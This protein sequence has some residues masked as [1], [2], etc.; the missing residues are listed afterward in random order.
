MSLPSG[1]IPVVLYVAVIASAVLT[2]TFAFQWDLIDWL[3]PFL[4]PLVWGVAWLFFGV[5]SVW[6]IVHCLANLR[7]WQRSAVPL[8]IC[9]ASLTI[10]FAVPFTALWVQFDFARKRDARERVVDLVTSGA[11]QPNVEYNPRLIRL[12]SSAPTVSK[13][14]NELVVQRDARGTYVFFYTFRGILDNYAGFLF[15]PP[16]GTPAT[17]G[18]FSEV[19]ATQL[20]KMADGWYF[21]SHR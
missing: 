13:G 2:A 19:N 6:T 9:V 8:T 20:V 18:D 16:N 15:V 11:L 7:V 17:F 5:A 3:T 1:R 14:G 21:A 12:D 10:V 4:M